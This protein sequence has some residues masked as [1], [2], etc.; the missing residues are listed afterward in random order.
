MA[1]VTHEVR[2]FILVWVCIWSGSILFTALA[3]MVAL[4]MGSTPG[5]DCVGR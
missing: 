4:A 3:V 2:Q 1:A 5:G